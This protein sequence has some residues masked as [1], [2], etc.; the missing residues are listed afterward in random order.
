MTHISSEISFLKCGIKLPNSA[1][2]WST[3]N[4]HFKTAF[5]NQPIIASD[6][7]SDIK[8]INNIIYAYFVDRHGYADTFPCRNN[9]ILQKYC[10]ASIKD[11]K[12]RRKQLKL[13][14]RDFDEIRLV[15]RYLRSKFSKKANKTTF[16]QKQ[17][18]TTSTLKG[19][20]GN[21]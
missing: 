11:L 1:H 8:T 16:R 12:K 21:M 15:S 5:S 19:T 9:S 6:V 13:N 2:E 14:E 3:A 7:D 17:L 10:S 4:K 18:T 20:T